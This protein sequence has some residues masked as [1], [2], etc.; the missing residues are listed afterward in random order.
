VRV[1][2]LAASG[3]AE[4]PRMRRTGDPWV[5]LEGVKFYADGWLGPRRA[6]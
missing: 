4:L 5:E 1:R 3:I 6:P 2:V